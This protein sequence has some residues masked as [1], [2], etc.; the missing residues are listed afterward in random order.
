MCGCILHYSKTYLYRKTRKKPGIYWN[1]FSRKVETLFTERPMKT[2]RY[3]SLYQTVK[4]ILLVLSSYMTLSY[5][6]FS[7]PSWRTY[8]LVSMDIFFSITSKL[9]IYIFK[10]LKYFCIFYLPQIN[11][12]NLLFHVNFCFIYYFSTWNFSLLY[13]WLSIFSQHVFID[14][15]NQ[16]LLSI[17]HIFLMPNFFLKWY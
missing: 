9:P 7:S 6:I 16:P 13:L 12:S 10:D 8:V 14:F 11:I 5:Y 3:C 15:I 2:T 17:L 1:Y 4:A